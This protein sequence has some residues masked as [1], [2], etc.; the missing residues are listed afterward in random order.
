MEIKL[1]QTV[2]DTITGFEGIVIGR[3]TYL[4][5]CTQCIV[6][7]KGL[8]KDGK[9]REGEWFD[10]QRLDPTS[11]KVVKLRPAPETPGCDERQP[12]THR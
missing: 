7:P 5:G 12:S 4:T 6:V 8:D 1:G 3:A 10:E 9:R 2:K 11:A